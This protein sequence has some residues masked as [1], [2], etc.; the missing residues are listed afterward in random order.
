MKIIPLTL[1]LPLLTG[2]NYST[3]TKSLMARD[4]GK[5]VYYFS[6]QKKKSPMFKTYGKSLSKNQ[7][8]P[9]VF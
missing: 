6:L 7:K 9:K 4:I 1:F 8:K 3:K 5:L 2:L